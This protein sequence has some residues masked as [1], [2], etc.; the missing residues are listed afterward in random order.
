MLPT[1]LFNIDGD[2]IASPSKAVNLPNCAAAATAA[3]CSVFAL[4]AGVECWC[5]SSDT[6]YAR[7]GKSDGCTTPCPW[8][9]GK[10]SDS[11]TSRSRYVHTYC[12]GSWANQVYKLY[13]PD[14]TALPTSPPVWMPPTATWTDFVPR[15]AP[16]MDWYPVNPSMN[17]YMAWNLT[18]QRTGGNTFGV[19]NG[20]AKGLA[21][22]TIKV[23]TFSSQDHS[24]WDYGQD[25]EGDIGLA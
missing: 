9:N 15:N 24:E 22:K 4:Q 5:G 19:V 21:V 8:E 17:A 3:G 7:L 1:L 23:W 2:S 6:D 25:G 16:P 14:P 11:P 20:C 12:G 10:A 13:I 18:A